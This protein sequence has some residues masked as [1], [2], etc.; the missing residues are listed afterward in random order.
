MPV[1]AT[2]KRVLIW[3]AASMPNTHGRRG[4]RAE[5][6]AGWDTQSREVPMSVLEKDVRGRGARLAHALT[7]AAPRSGP[8]PRTTLPMRVL[9]AVGSAAGDIA[10]TLNA[11][12]PSFSMFFVAKSSSAASSPE[13]G[14]MRIALACRN[15]QAKHC[16][17]GA[18]RVINTALHQPLSSHGRC[19]RTEA[20]S[21]AKGG[22]SCRYRSRNHPPSFC[23]W[24]RSRLGNAWQA[25]QP[26]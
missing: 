1:R 2:G 21:R 7:N 6:E 11:S 26:R 8:G 22:A 5:Q 20:K 25:V 4:L 19:S 9:N 3:K 23:R 12:S 15:I 24:I 10:L 13:R 18:W 17:G 14:F 16:A